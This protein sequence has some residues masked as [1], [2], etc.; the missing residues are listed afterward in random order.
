VDRK[1]WLAVM[2]LDKSNQNLNI[3]TLQVTCLGSFCKTVLRTNDTMLL[4][5]TLRLH[6]HCT[7]TM[8]L[9]LC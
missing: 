4:D 2:T 3:L 7:Q 6:V 8:Y 9:L 1:P 5:F